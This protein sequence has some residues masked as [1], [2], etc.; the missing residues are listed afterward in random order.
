MRQ[1]FESRDAKRFGWKRVDKGQEQK[2]K[3]KGG[4][5]LL[6]KSATLTQKNRPHLYA[7]HF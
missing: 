1:H 4:T 2:K 5:P 6:E 3:K 7:G